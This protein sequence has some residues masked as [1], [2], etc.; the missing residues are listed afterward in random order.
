VPVIYK[1]YVAAAAVR[2]FFQ[3]E[4]GGLVKRGT[5]SCNIFSSL[6]TIKCMPC[7][8]CMHQ[9]QTHCDMSVVVH[10]GVG[11]KLVCC[12]KKRWRRDFN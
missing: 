8:P 1:V 6:A 2:D 10:A 7:M 4:V 3:N 11:L 9:L 12:I 5:R